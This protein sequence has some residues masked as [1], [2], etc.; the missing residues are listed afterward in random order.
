MLALNIAHLDEGHSSQIR[1]VTPGELELENNDVFISPIDVRFEIDKVGHE[2]YIKANIKTKT[3]LLCDRCAEPY[4]ENLDESVRIVITSDSELGNP[5]EDIYSI[6]ASST[7]I[8]ITESI[9]ETLLISLPAKRLCKADCK[10]LCPVCGTKLNFE[11]CSCKTDEI[12]PRWEA[13]KKLKG[14]EKGK[15]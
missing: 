2:F 11:T 14:N 10:G 13:L 3:H 15:Y 9:K 7:E 6:T 8:D 5:E 1:Q 12:D 4:D